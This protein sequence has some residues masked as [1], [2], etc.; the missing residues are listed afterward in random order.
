MR[1]C[2][3]D[4]QGVS[5]EPRHPCPGAVHLLSERRS[6]AHLIGHGRKEADSSGASAF[7]HTMDIACMRWRPLHGETVRYGR[8]WGE[9]KVGYP[10]T[11]LTCKVMSSLM[12]DSDDATQLGDFFVELVEPDPGQHD[13]ITDLLR[14]SSVTP[15]ALSPS[16]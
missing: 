10:V 3:G 7:I 13:E 8:K 12:P 6:I 16:L 4:W 1:C 15:A 9:R 14:P 5:S 2:R 11:A